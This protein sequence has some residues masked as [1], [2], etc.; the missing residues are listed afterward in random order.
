MCSQRYGLENI[1]EKYFPL[2][3]P[4]R[5]SKEPQNVQQMKISVNYQ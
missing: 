3:F 2:E 1:F 4:Q 5:N